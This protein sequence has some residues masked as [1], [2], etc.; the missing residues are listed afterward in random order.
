MLARRPASWSTTARPIEA[1]YGTVTEHYAGRVSVEAGTFEQR[2]ESD[3]SFTLRFHEP[4][5]ELTTRATLDVRGT[6]ESYDVSID[7]VCSEN[8]AEVAR[9]SWH[10]SGVPRGEWTRRTD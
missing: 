2:A 7:L 5:V 3:V 10:S 4:G 8:D 9:R 6:A 1:P